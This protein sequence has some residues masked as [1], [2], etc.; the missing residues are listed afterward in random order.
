LPL[1]FMSLIRDF[2][3][4][5]GDRCSVTPRANASSSPIMIR[6]HKHRPTNKREH[7]FRSNHSPRAPLIQC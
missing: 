5:H 2:V 6:T 3:A 7:L 1:L 4:M